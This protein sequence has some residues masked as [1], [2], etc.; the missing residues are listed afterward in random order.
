[1]K[2][3]FTFRR[4]RSSGDS[5]IQPAF[6]SLQQ[7]SAGVG[8]I[9]TEFRS[10]QIFVSPDFT[11]TVELPKGAPKDKFLRPIMWVLS[12]TLSQ[13]LLIISPH[14]ANDQLPEI[15]KSPKVRLHVFAPRISHIGCDSSG[16]DFYSIGGESR[17]RG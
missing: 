16:L 4:S 11:L 10:M 7:T 17:T 12:S 1:M 13:N 6:E 9:P 15:R 2:G 14:E 8:S 3:E 5:T